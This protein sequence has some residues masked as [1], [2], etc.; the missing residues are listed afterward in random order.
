MLINII[1]WLEN[2][3]LPCLYEKLFGI[4]CPGC[5]TQRAIIELL[6]GNFQESFHA[7]PPLLP[8]MFMMV[9]LLLFLKFRFKNGITVLKITFIINASLI[10]INYIYRLI[11]HLT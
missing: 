9:Y 10:T 8:V 2:H 3:Q 5:G 6:R 4:E 7:W 1:N 11:L